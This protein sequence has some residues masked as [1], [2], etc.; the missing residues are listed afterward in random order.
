MTIDGD[1]IVF[2]P[3]VYRPLRPVVARYPIQGQDAWKV[4]LGSN[5]L[6]DSIRVSGS[7]SGAC[8]TFSLIETTVDLKTCRFAA[9]EAVSIAYTYARE[10]R[11]AFDLG[12]LDFDPKDYRWKVSVDGQEAFNYILEKNW[13]SFADLP[14]N[15]QVEVQVFR[16]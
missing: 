12:S 2:P 1:E 11:S 6:V 10:H 4:Q 14:L 13:L 8:E 3:N 5:I 15:S 9:S 16:K 7:Q